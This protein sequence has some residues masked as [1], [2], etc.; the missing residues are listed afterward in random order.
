M[1]A[2]Y[3]YTTRNTE[4]YYFQNK[5]TGERLPLCISKYKDDYRLIER[6]EV[7]HFMTLSKVVGHFETLE[8][9]CE[10]IQEAM[11]LQAA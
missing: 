7:T 1:F 10:F 5:L 4:E 8:D 9:A 2:M 6:K 3:H 11:I